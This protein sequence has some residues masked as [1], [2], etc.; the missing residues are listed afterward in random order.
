MTIHDTHGPVAAARQDSGISTG[1][2]LLLLAWPLVVAAAAVAWVTKDVDTRIADGLAERPAIA[3][4]DTTAFVRDTTPSGDGDRDLVAALA[5]ADAA[6]KT[7]TDAG[8]VVLN[9]QAVAGHPPAVAVPT[10]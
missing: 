2:F 9:S 3:V 10:R 6:T 7:L 4:L 8:F 1:T 5:R